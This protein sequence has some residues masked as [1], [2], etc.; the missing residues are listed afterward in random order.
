MLIDIEKEQNDTVL[1]DSVRLHVRKYLDSEPN[2]SN[3]K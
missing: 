3:R 2:E 1:Q